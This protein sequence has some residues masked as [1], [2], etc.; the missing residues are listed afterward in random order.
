MKNIHLI[1]MITIPLIIIIMIRVILIL[2]N[3]DLMD[4]DAQ[5]DG[6]E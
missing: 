6:N 4:K 3:I 1:I 5:K 2:M